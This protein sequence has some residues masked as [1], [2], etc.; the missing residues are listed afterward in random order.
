VF[1]VVKKAYV[2]HGIPSFAGMMRMMRMMRR[3]EAHSPVFGFLGLALSAQLRNA[4]PVT[5]PH[6]RASTDKNARPRLEILVIQFNF[7]SNG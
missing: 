7:F 4:P 6:S 3:H 5:P 1:G 2:V